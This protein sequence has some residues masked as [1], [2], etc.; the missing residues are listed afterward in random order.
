MTFGITA[1]SNSRQ[2]GHWRSMYSTRVA[3]ADGEPSTLSCWGIPLN[4]RVATPASG[5][6]VTFVG[7]VD[8]ELLLLSVT[9]ST[10]ATGITAS[11]ISPATAASTFGFAL[12]PLPVLRTGG[13]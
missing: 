4:R 12:R 10:I 6:V 1:V 9:A 5:S 11:A 2:T 8:E 3:G 7:V 13:G